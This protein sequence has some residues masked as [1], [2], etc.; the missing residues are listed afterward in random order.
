MR[1]AR[2]VIPAATD[3]LA[4]V[5]AIVRLEIARGSGPL[6][7]RRRRRGDRHPRV[8]PV[9]ETRERIRIVRVEDA[10]QPSLLVSV[11]RPTHHSSPAP[12]WTVDPLRQVAEQEP[13]RTSRSRVALGSA[14]LE[15]AS[16]V[17]W[18]S[19]GWRWRLS[20][21]RA[22]AAGRLASSNLQPIPTPA[23]GFSWKMRQSIYIGTGRIAVRPSPYLPVAI[24]PRRYTH[25]AM[26]PEAG[27]TLVVTVVFLVGLLG[28]AG[29]V[30]D[31]GSL[32][33]Q[34]QAVQAA[35]DAAAIAGA[36]Q[37]PAGWS[38]AQAAASHEYLLNGK[39]PDS[40]TTSQTTNLTAGDSVTVTASRTAPT[41][42]A[43]LFGINSAPIT[44]TARA[45]VESYTSY[46][47]TGNVL[48]F[49]VMQGEL[50]AGAVLHHL[51]RRKLVEQ[52]R[53]VARPQVRRRLQRGQRRQRPA[54]H[55][56]WQRHRLPCLCR[57]GRRHQTWQEHRPCRP[58]PEHPHHHLGAVQPDR[59]DER[60]RAIH[61]ARPLESPTRADPHRPRH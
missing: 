26:R 47:S 29:L 54:R 23:G 31:L 48:P 4:P 61:P 30:I 33:Q 17:T 5:A 24:L 50:P 41:F 10:E 34:R 16:C 43:R 39:A 42:F 49:G 13:R 19:T 6:T 56:R 11:A 32:Y 25:P 59:P 21:A 3:R 2:V 37:L 1:R 52:R 60:K 58:R 53:A 14:P 9:G 55:D 8:Y 20:L 45:T 28:I 7:V 40:V 15:P 22:A 38:A 44:A 51:R 36:S 27:Q 18:A 57:T 46:T 12:S 35:A